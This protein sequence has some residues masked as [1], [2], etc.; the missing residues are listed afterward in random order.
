MGEGTSP[1]CEEEVHGIQEENRD[2]LPPR[3][4]LVEKFA[5]D[6]SL[7]LLLRVSSRSRLTAGPLAWKVPWKVYDKSRWAQNKYEL[8]KREASPV[9]T[10]RG[11]NL[12]KMQ[13]CIQPFSLHRNNLGGS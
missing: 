11:A 4:E 5:D 7:D 12:K 3:G 1:S 9:M 6:W 2:S 13:P 10:I 8:P